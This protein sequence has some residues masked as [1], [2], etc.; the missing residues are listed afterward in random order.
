MDHSETTDATRA[1]EKVFQQMKEGHKKDI[2]RLIPF[3]KTN[4]NKAVL[5]ARHTIGEI[6]DEDFCREME[7]LES[8]DSNNSSNNASSSASSSASV[9]LKVKGLGSRG[10]SN[11][12]KHV[13]Y[14][15]GLFDFVD[16]ET[17]RPRVP[18]VRERLVPNDTVKY[19]P[20][21]TAESTYYEFETIISKFPNRK[22]RLF[23]ICQQYLS[24]EQMEYQKISFRSNCED[25][26]RCLKDYVKAKIDTLAA[27]TEPSVVEL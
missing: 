21:I 27:G 17:G 1:V 13:G 12:R 26:K 20:P 22:D 18:H 19:L 4:S 23:T 25:Y 6:D 24:K 7:K 5:L 11:K 10:Q 8:N 14:D 16:S 9:S 15:G 2:S 3:M